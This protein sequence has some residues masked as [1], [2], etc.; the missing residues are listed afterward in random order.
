MSLTDH[1]MVAGGSAACACG[2]RPDRGV[3]GDRPDRGVCGDRPDR[4]D[5]LLLVGS[6]SANDLNMSCP[7][8]DAPTLEA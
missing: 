8:V 6:F 3:C 2:D 4:G 1:R 7:Y 5:G